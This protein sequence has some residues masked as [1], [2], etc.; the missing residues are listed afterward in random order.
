MD[1]ALP[2]W[3]GLR[4]VPGVRLGQAPAGWC[5]QEDDEAV[6][7]ETEW[8]GAHRGRGAPHGDRVPRQLCS[9]GLDTQNLILAA[10]E[11]D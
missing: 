5:G 10:C 3:R 6:D 4:V 9:M 8:R 1:P 2:R 7:A 11:E